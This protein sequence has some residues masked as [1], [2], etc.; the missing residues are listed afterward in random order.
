VKK[1]W[2][3]VLPFVIVGGF[4]C[5]TKPV[6]AQ[7]TGLVPV[8]AKVGVFLP[9][10]DA[11]DF[12]G[13]THF[14]AEADVTV[15]IALFGPGRTVVTA[16]F[17]Q[18]SDDGRKLRMIPVTIGKV[19]S[20]PNPAGRITGNVYFGA[21]VGAYFLRASDDGDSESKT[22]PGAYA[23]AGYQFPSA[24]FVEAKYHVVGSVGG[25][26]PNGLAI[27]VGRQF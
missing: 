14:N 20:P 26:S 17:Y 15:P 4:V 27:M 21:G 8:R 9:R 24:F 1:N 10:G 7:G 23:M 19:F 22:R 16:G 18:G 12:A 5:G 13:S 11:R 2:K 6:A 25:I 3:A